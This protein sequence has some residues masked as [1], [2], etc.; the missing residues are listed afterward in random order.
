MFKI[1]YERM[2]LNMKKALIAA[3]CLSIMLFACGCRGNNTNNGGAGNGGNNMAQDAQNMANDAGNA[4]E[5][6]AQSIFPDELQNKDSEYFKV[7][8]YSKDGNTV[9]LN[10]SVMRRSTADDGKIE[11][12]YGKQDSEL[13]FDADHA[14]ITYNEDGVSNDTTIKFSAY[15]DKH[16]D[17]IKEKIYK[18]EL[19]EGRV[20][21]LSEAGYTDDK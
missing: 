4:I 10:G 13:T 6:I 2:I 9:T 15:L 3:M 7:T 11:Y 1:N 19:E 20:R 16:G 5:D 14:E 17:S 12:E 21:R 8:D 18:V